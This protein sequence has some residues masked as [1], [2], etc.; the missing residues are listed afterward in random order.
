MFPV[1]DSWGMVGHHGM[2]TAQIVVQANL[3]LYLDA[4]LQ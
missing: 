2:R 4:T 1:R 3:S